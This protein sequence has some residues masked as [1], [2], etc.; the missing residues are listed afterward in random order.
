MPERRAV[1]FEAH[2]GKAVVG[3]RMQVD[4]HAV[5]KGALQTDPFEPHR[6]STPSSVPPVGMGPIVNVC[7]APAAVAGA[8][9]LVN[10]APQVR[11]DDMIVRPPGAQSPV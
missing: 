10:V 9:S 2:E 5:G 11:D 4:G 7:V 6:M 8:T 1:T 3:Y